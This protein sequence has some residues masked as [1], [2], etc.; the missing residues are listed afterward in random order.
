M[1]FSIEASDEPLVIEILR[2]HEVWLAYG[3][4]LLKW[5]EFTRTKELAKE[6]ALH[7]RIL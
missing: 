5:G 1:P 7:A 6:V 2:T 3:E 4:E